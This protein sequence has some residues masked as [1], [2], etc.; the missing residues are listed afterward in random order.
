MANGESNP[1]G[2]YN[3]LLNPEALQ[4][5]PAEL[6][7]VLLPPLK[8]ALAGSLHSVFLIAMGVA[9]A[10]IL[11]SLLMGNLKMEKGKRQVL[12]NPDELA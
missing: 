8:T 10:G 1:Q 2:L 7:Q 9:L 12:K 5:I 6:Q 11:V 4:S 3:Y